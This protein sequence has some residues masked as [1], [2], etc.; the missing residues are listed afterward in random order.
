MC[1]AGALIFVLFAHIFAQSSN[2][3]QA[4]CVSKL[5]K[6]TISVECTFA[7]VLVKYLLA[8]PRMRTAKGKVSQNVLTWS[9]FNR[10]R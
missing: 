4:Q 6:G 3:I 8:A 9:P 5:Q 7:C 2:L 1:M 10:H